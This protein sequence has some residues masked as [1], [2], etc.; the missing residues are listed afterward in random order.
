MFA[1]GFV[2]CALLG[3]SLSSRAQAQSVQKRD[4]RWKRFGVDLLVVGGATTAAALGIANVRHAILDRGSWGHVGRNISHPIQQV[5]LGTRRDTDP[6]AI[7]FVAHPLSYAGMGLYLKERGYRDWNAFL[8]TQ[9][10]SYVWEFMIE[11]S[12]VPPSGKDLLSNLAASSVAIFALD[13]ISRYGERQ[14]GEPSHAWYH[15]LLHWTNPLNPLHD[16]LRK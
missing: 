3:C 11:G 8:F 13:R 7:N 5:R 15:H 14:L 16:L 12:G 1:A 2:T 9:A 4:D 6:F 10:H